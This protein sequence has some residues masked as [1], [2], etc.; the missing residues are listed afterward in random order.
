MKK[1]LMQ[2]KLLLRHFS[3]LRVH[4]NKKDLRCWLLIKLLGLIK[5][6]EKVIE[7]DPLKFIKSYSTPGD[8]KMLLSDSMV[9][10]KAQKPQNRRERKNIVS[11]V[12][13]VLPKDLVDVSRETDDSATESK[14]IIRAVNRIRK[15]VDGKTMKV[16]E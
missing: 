12:T 5:V 14:D 15:V 16:Q 8:Q 10:K 1:N 4:N 2:H 6:K 9:A 7:F 3:H 11:K 13:P